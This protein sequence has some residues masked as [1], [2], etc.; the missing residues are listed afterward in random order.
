[1]Y[2]VLLF[3]QII[4]ELEGSPRLPLTQGLGTA[5]LVYPH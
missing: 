3:W 5:V 2:F 4:L 1:M